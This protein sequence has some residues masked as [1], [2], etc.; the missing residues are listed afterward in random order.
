[1]I[2]AYFISGLGADQRVFER[3]KL[4]PQIKVH[5]IAWLA[6]LRGE[7]L[8]E[9]AIRMGKAIELPEK[10]VLI[11]LSF[12]GV[13]AIEIAKQIHVAHVIIISS[14]KDKSEM[15]LQLNL[16]ALFKLHH[17]IPASKLLHFKD[18]VSWFF[19]VKDDAAKAMFNTLLDETDEA[20]VDWSSEQILSWQGNHH[21]KSLTHIHGTADTVFP[22][23][24]VNA[25]Y[26]IP[27]GP[28]FMVFT[29]A[30]EVSKLL[31]KI[32]LRKIIPNLKS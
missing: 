14:V 24:S 10:S 8:S 2:N 4:D 23:K 9:Y 27:G 21:L 31:N 16:I 32:I 25:D 30:V 17:L 20:L 18:L 5:H 19:G 12:G 11:G 3:L 7:G 28:H 13:M 26:I 6:P 1:M 22:I 15:P 29:H